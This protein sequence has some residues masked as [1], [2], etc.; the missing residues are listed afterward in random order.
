MSDKFRSIE[1]DLYDIKETTEEPCGSKTDSYLAVKPWIYIRNKH[2]L[3]IAYS[4]SISVNCDLDLKASDMIFGSNKAS[5][6]TMQD[7]IMSWI[8]HAFI[9]VYE[10]RLSTDFDLDL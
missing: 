4:H 1:A 5:R 2:I 3:I 8:Q 7:N 9:V 10:Q 6:Q